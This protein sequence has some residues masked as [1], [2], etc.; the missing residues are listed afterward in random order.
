MNC[1]KAFS[2]A[3]TALIGTSAAVGMTLPIAKPIEASAQTEYKYSTQQQ[4]ALKLL[5]DYRVKSGLKPVTLNPYLTKA[6]QK[7]HANFLLANG[8][9]NYGHDEKKGL[10]GYTGVDPESRVKAVGYTPPEI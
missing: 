2:L 7:N 6:S 5:N 3:L 8:Y 1:S 9:A 10:K 4:A